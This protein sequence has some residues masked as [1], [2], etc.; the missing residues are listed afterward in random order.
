MFGPLGVCVKIVETRNGSVTSTKQLVGDEE[1]D[2]AG[3]VTR[4][5]FKHGEI[6]SGA[7]YFFIRDHLGSVHEIADSAGTIQARYGY[8]LYGRTTKIQGS[9]DADFQY[10]GMYVH[11]SSGLYLTPA[12]QY[13]A[14][15][16][17]WLSRDPSGEGAGANPYAYASN[18]PSI[19]FDPNGLDSVQFTVFPVGTAFWKLSYGI[20]PPGLNLLAHAGLLINQCDKW[21]TV[22]GA[23]KNTASGAMVSLLISP[24]FSSREEAVRQLE[25]NG[26]FVWGSNITTNK[27]DV[28]KILDA[29]REVSSHLDAS[30]LP[31]RMV[32]DAASWTSNQALG[33][34]LKRSRVSWSG[35]EAAPFY[36][37]W[38]R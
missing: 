11:A 32:P 29:A 4:Q 33:L 25:A 20:L 1:R 27:N 8:D 21:Y 31:Y 34:A 6:I 3:S 26:S 28:Q 35:F 38:L 5:F 19:F 9:V 15:L 10:A 23:W 12:R 18:S 36:F 16:G 30:N 13:S 7:S 14:N 24:A 2:S 17:T 22:N 37:P